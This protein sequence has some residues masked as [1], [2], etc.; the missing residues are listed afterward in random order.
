MAVGA[1]LAL[2]PSERAYMAEMSTWDLDWVPPGYRGID[3]EDVRAWCYDAVGAGSRGV[4]RARWSDEE[5][6]AGLEEIRRFFETCRAPVRWYVGPS[7]TSARL[8]AALRERASGVYEPRLMTADL[9]RVR[10]HKSDVDVAEMRDLAQAR[11]MLDAAFPDMPPRA[12][13]LAI[14]E[15]EAY[16]AAQRRGGTL[17][18]YRADEIV[19]FG[20]WRDAS[21]GSAV[22]L[23]GGWTTPAERGRGVYSTLTA[24]RCRAAAS[25]GIRYAATVAD[26]TTSA[27]ILAHAGF[28]DHGPLRIFNAVAL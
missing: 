19:G 5:V 6:P 10:F 22:Q 2:G 8:V 4:A 20:A 27:P 21:D 1:E 23:I 28:A 18:A 12:R 16:L 26:P 11:A 15:A 14:T 9:G 13:A 7:T 25:R 17:L 24:E 3:R